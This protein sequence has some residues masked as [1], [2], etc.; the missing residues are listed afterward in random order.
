MSRAAILTAIYNRTLDMTIANGYNYDWSI[1]KSDGNGARVTGDTVMHLVVGAEEPLEDGVESQLEY[2]LELPVEIM[3]IS[4][5][6]TASTVGDTQYITELTRA[7]LADDIR[8][9]FRIAFDGLCTAGGYQILYTGETGAESG[10]KKDN[11][12]AEVS[13][14]YRIRFRHTGANS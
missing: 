6:S 9:A 5:K 7:K 12:E 10:L 11:F 1:L 14:E 2:N 3:G 8:K 4:R 13:L